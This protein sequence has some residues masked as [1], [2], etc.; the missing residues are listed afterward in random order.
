MQLTNSDFDP[1]DP[2]NMNMEEKFNYIKKSLTHY[3]SFD[4][5]HEKIEPRVFELR[6]VGIWLEFPIF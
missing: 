2:Q 4:I 1:N 3:T 5:L 6:K